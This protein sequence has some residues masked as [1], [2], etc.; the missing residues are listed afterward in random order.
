MNELVY[1]PT[2]SHLLDDLH[3]IFVEENMLFAYFLWGK[4]DRV[5][6]DKGVLKLFGHVAVNAIAEVFYRC[7]T[8]L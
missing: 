1:I 4:L 7:T 8:T 6:P 5:T 3:Y 2:I